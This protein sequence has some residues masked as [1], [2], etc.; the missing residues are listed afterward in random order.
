MAQ[1][2]IRHLV[3][4]P[5]RKGS[6]RCFWQ[7][8][9][10]LRKLGWRGH[11]LKD[12]EGN[13]LPLPQAIA[14]AEA[15]N[16]QLDAWRQ[17][18]RAAG[19]PGKPPAADSLSALIDAYKAS[20]H[21]QTKR[22]ATKKGYDHLLAALIR[23]AGDTP[24]AAITA[25]RVQVLYESLYDRTPGRA[26]HLITML[27]TVMA[28]AVRMGKLPTN[29]VSKPRL[30]GNRPRHQ[31]WPESGMEA[32]V[33]AADA[34][35]Y[36]SL[37]TAVMMAFFLAQ[38]PTDVREMTRASYRDGKFIFRQSKTGAAVDVPA[39]A[40]LQRRIAAE[41][42]RHDHL[43]ILICETTGRPWT[44]DNLSHVFARARAAALADAPEIGDLLFR[45][46]RRTGVVQL[47]LAGNDVPRIASVSGH[48]LKTVHEILET[49]LPRT[50]ELAAQAIANLETYRAQAKLKGGG[51]L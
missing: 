33:R 41:L 11:A 34:M 5:G 37:G 45:D 22:P 7:P 28:Y 47:A 13:F 24:I 49:Y 14:A 31:V 46:F 6:V 30:M 8:A 25:P 42:A 29:P 15:M 19:L 35:G 26:N 39:V 21:Y 12:G 50:S 32:A 38:R 18:D 44:E 4:K 9:P 16:V 36:H 3:V 17:G 23:W 51:G 2:K 10:A 20:R 48:S 40:E 27:R 43:T 1:L